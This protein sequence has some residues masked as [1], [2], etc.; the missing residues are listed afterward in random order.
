MVGLCGYYGKQRG[1][2]LA[3]RARKFIVAYYATIRVLIRFITV[4]P[5]YDL[6]DP[7]AGS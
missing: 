3:A 7:A 2:R 4:I 5:T 6:K 1:S